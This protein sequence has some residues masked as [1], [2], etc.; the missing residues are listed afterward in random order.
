MLNLSALRKGNY[1]NAR[2]VAPDNRASNCGV[3][4][5]RREMLGITGV[6]V[7]GA[8]P[9]LGA[10]RAALS[11]AVS[12]THDRLRAA[13]HLD[14]T[15]RWVID[16]R[17]FG[18]APRLDVREERDRVL[19][20]LN[21][22]LFP[23]TWLPAD[24]ACE[25]TREA[26]R[27][28]MRLRLALAGSDCTA[29]F[30]AWLGGAATARS[31][32]GRDCN[33]GLAS[34]ATN[35]SLLA[36]DVL[37]FHPSWFL[38]AAGPRGARLRR[39][40]HDLSA[41]TVSIRLL[42]PGEP[43]LLRHPMTKRTLVEV[44]R[45]GATWGVSPELTT[46]EGALSALREDPFDRARVETGETARG[47]VRGVLLFDTVGGPPNLS[48]SPGREMTA[49]DGTPFTLP[50]AAARFAVGLNDAAAQTALVAEFADEPSIL[51]VRGCKL[52][53]GRGANSQPFE[54]LAS[55]GRIETIRCA[56]QLLDVSAPLPDAS[57]ISSRS[58]ANT[59][60]AFLDRARVQVEGDEGSFAVGEAAGQ[61]E[62][63]V[64][65]SEKVV[66]RAEDLL[67][68]T[69]KF[70]N[71]RLRL[72][73]REVARIVVRNPATEGV[74]TMLF[75]P[76]HFGEE[77][78]P[79]HQPPSAGTR[80]RARMAGASRLS[81][82]V[83]EAGGGAGSPGIPYTLEG[84]LNACRLSRL[85]LKGR[86]AGKPADDETAIEAPYRLILSPNDASAWLHAAC[87]IT[88]FRPGDCAAQPAGEV[89]RTELWHT[90]L[91]V[92]GANNQPSEG[93]ETRRTLRAVWARD[94]ELA[95][96]DPDPFP[97]ILPFA[98]QRKE[99]VELTSVLETGPIRARQLMLSALGAWMRVE[100]SEPPPTGLSLELWLHHAT[101]GRDQY[102]KTVTKGYLYPWRHLASH[103][104]I[105]DRRF[106]AVGRQVEAVLI[107][108]DFLVIKRPRT[109][110]YPSQPAAPNGG[111]RMLPRVTLLDEQAIRIFP[112]RVEEPSQDAP[113]NAPY[114]WPDVQV[115]PGVFRHYAF[116]ASADD[117][118]G[119]PVEFA[120]G[121]I[122]VE[123]TLVERGDVPDAVRLGYLADASLYARD[124]DLRH[125]EVAFA[126]PEGNANTV[127]EAA[128]IV[129]GAEHVP[130]AS[131]P[132]GQKLVPK[133]FPLIETVEGHIPAVKQLRADD[134]PAV[135]SYNATYVQ[136]GFTGANRGKVFMNLRSPLRLDFRG[137][138]DKPGAFFRPRLNVVG[139]SS[140]TGI[141]GGRATGN[142]GD[143]QASLQL[144]SEGKFD[145]E[146]FFEGL[147]LFGTDDLRKYVRRIDNFPAALGDVPQLAYTKALSSGG[148][149]ATARFSWHTRLNPQPGEPTPVLDFDASRETLLGVGGSAH[150]RF[151]CELDGYVTK[152]SDVRIRYGKLVYRDETGLPTVVETPVLPNTPGGQPNVQFNGDLRFVQTL[153][154]LFATIG[155][156]AEAHVNE[157]V[158]TLSFGS[159][160]PNIDFGLF[161][162]H[163]LSVYT[164]ISLGYLGTRFGVEFKIAD[165]SSPCSLTVGPFY[166]KAHF[167]VRWSLLPSLA[168]AAISP[169]LALALCPPSID[170]GFE[171]GAHLGFDVFVAS[172]SLSVSVGIRF[173][174]NMQFFLELTGFL[175]CHGS[176]SVGP[177]SA[178]VGF[179]AQ[180][181][182]RN[183]E[184]FCSAEL[185]IDVDLFLFSI[186]VGVTV[187]FAFKGS[188]F[189]AG[190]SP[191]EPRRDLVAGMSW[192]VDP[193]T[194]G[195]AALPAAPPTPGFA[196][197]MSEDDWDA[198][199]EAFA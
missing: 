174:L 122:F 3:T 197:Q 80:V 52:R 127:A 23:G 39:A 12:F 138:T 146:H 126:P 123:A 49:G 111:R 158:L 157:G 74:I 108:T 119:E 35:L 54:L 107:R 175:H 7:L 37:T 141:V 16:T 25:L 131:L 56:P 45:G 117:Y 113:A 17:R 145:P 154:G 97:N 179:D 182:L 20:S 199:C 24:F 13:F 136:E 40:A 66:V 15:E 196:E 57:V 73:P 151:K 94:M 177:F 193:G 191:A 102:V 152:N 95:A 47:D 169:G 81:F 79:E 8:A 75:Q 59:R 181:R 161:R 109:V 163:N 116:K 128:R 101:M 42:D 98:R 64:P 11:G 180:L 168:L 115:A 77:H 26:G 171:F 28:R 63:V 18:G 198:Y 48:F 147:E 76:Q 155:I 137:Q 71:L 139:L 143:A 2:S 36:G 32:V 100:Y 90:R 132:P 148:V 41:D 149:R 165:P 159:R 31:V 65:L 19:L 4:I 176:M 60:L 92:R 9:A 38:S 29:P 153:A 166:G 135:L 50:L 186:H 125:Q 172:L 184:L 62:A 58:P 14:G 6:A 124:L 178:G 104:R 96:A 1:P 194:A 44:P 103:V 87:P 51:S 27:W 84:I 129:F 85:K 189:L 185:R 55:G 156:K 88:Q 22:A 142:A 144:F 112:K 167:V 33:A 83:H 183:D 187:E 53:V 110:H 173:Q 99:L 43:S 120:P 69:L 70:K 46:H 164:L 140:L 150:A 10:L 89:L 91:G 61:V 170:T 190:L 118:R 133:F 86:G 121:A 82:V 78:F 105:V 67:V 34:A 21:G 188:P 5:S 68:L 72:S 192:L 162:L 134:T 106:I 30:A 93:D 195:Q 160:L 114:F 130:E